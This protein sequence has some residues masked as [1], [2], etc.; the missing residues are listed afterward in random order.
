LAAAS[1]VVAGFVGGGCRR[2][3]WLGSVFAVG[4]VCYHLQ[5]WFCL[6]SVVLGIG[7]AAIPAGCCCCLLMCVSV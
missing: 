4:A 3:F 5:C 2:V 6:F 1:C 7:M